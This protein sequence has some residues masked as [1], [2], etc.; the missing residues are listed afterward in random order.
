[1]GGRDSVFGKL[2]DTDKKSKDSGLYVPNKMI[3]KEG[4]LESVHSTPLV[5]TLRKIYACISPEEA[6][7]QKAEEEAEK[8]E[9]RRQWGA[10]MQGFFV[11]H[12]TRVDLSRG[13][14]LVDS[15]AHRDLGRD[16]IFFVLSG[17]VVERCAT[18]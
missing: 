11:R 16:A 9:R 8:K 18:P 3:E 1:M 17:V 2:L 4:R 14:V 13:E 5:D 15:S 7:R 10:D 12:G 6:A